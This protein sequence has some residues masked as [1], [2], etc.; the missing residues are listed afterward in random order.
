[1]IKTGIM[2][3]G[4]EDMR[5]IVAVTG[6]TGVEMSRYLMQALK[7]TEHCEVHLII[8]EGAKLTWALESSAPIEK[9]YAL[10]D[11]VYNEKNLAAAIASGSC[12]TDGMVV[13]PCSMKSLAGIVSGY[14]EN[15]ILRAADVCMKEGRKLVLVPREMPL[16]RVHLRNL[17]EA[18]DMGCVIIPPMLTFYSGAQTVEDQIHHITGKILMQFGLEYDRFKS[19]KGSDRI[20]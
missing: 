3:M 4:K 13:I 20:L 12:V 2:E 18:A 16:G 11:K 7:N 15:L 5:I 17:K 14:A 9:V 1:M 8:S 6:A 19:W 10:A